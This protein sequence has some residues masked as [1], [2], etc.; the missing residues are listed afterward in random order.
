MTSY[1]KYGTLMPSDARAWNR[2]QNLSTVV[3]HLLKNIGYT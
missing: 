2:M 3:P 1:K